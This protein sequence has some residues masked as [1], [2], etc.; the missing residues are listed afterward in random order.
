MNLN[1]TAYIIYGLLMFYIIYFLGRAFH[2]NGR[3]FI[4]RLYRGNEAGTDSI[5]NLLLLGYYLFNSGYVLLLLKTWEPVLHI[6]QLIA[7]LSRHIGLLVIMLALMHYMNMLVIYILSKK[8]N[9]IHLHTK[10]YES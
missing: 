5:N 10:T 8:Q 7:S 3:V 6:Q 4:L 2:Q 9:N 1:I